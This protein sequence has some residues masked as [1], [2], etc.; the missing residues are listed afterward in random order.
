MP[1]TNDAPNIMLSTLKLRKFGTYVMYDPHIYRFIVGALQYVTLTRPDISF[2]VNKAC[3]FMASP[4]NSH[5]SAVKRILRYLSGTTYHGL[6]LLPI[7]PE[8]QTSLHAYNDS[9]WASDMD[10]KRST[11]GSCIFLWAKLGGITFQEEVPHLQITNVEYCW[12][13]HSTLEL[14]WIESLLTELHIPFLPPTLLRDN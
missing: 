11:S 5:W 7:K 6:K 10:D 9:D 12:L 1:N 8:S 4:L 3:Q 2:S 14:L 13:A